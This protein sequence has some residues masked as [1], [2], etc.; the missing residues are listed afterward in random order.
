LLTTV[1]TRKHDA[2]V[3]EE[4]A[5]LLAVPAPGLSWQREGRFGPQRVITLTGAGD[6]GWIDYTVP[7][8]VRLP[9]EAVMVGPWNDP[10]DVDWATELL[11]SHAYE[12]PVT[13]SAIPIR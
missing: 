9:I 2:Y 12:V 3:S 8:P 5:R 11:R 1:Y 4:E 6:A 7:E 10:S 13:R